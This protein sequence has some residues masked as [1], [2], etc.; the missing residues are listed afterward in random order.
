MAR[1]PRIEFP[2]GLY[3][4]IT[5]GNRKERIFLDDPD[6]RRYL[7]L[8]EHYRKRYKF[9]LYAYTLMPNHTHSL[10][11][12][13]ETPISRIMQGI[14]QSYTQYFNKKYKKVGHLF[15]GRYKALLCDKDKYLLAL[16]R[17]IH[18][19]PVRA[20]IVESPD[21]YAWSSH[22]IYLGKIKQDFAD[23]NFA[24]SMFSEGKKTSIRRY[25]Q[26]VKKGMEEKQ[27]EEFEIGEFVGDKTFAEEMR[28][29]G[30]TRI[31]YVILLSIDEI[32]SLIAKEMGMPVD[33]LF[34]KSHNRKY[35]RVRGITGYLM[36][37]IVGFKVT[38][39]ANYFGRDI[40]AVSKEIT[41]I[42][43]EIMSDVGFQK[44]LEKI[45]TA[46]KRPNEEK[47]ANS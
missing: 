26:F 21:D 1:K 13:N 3:H 34:L 36:R 33:A 35:G 23:K 14:N 22:N 31:S 17:Y 27:E 19:N 25:I 37:K 43:K 15:Q 41:K 9:L 46:V 11:E 40:A 6:Y 5:R 39:I 4:V 42:E 7:N 30:S 10:I 47:Y 28:S 38:D 29:K 44:T 12:Q 16:I 45:E 32:A 18:L 8:L 24:L 20:R 2:G